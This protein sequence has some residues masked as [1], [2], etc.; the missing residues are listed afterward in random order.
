MTTRNPVRVYDFTLK[1][2]DIDEDDIK[3]ILKK[4]CKKWTFQLEEGIKDGYMHY[5]GRIHL[6]EK[7]RF[8]QMKTYQPFKNQCSWSVTSSGNINNDDYVEKSDTRVKG[9]WS[10]DDPEPMYVP[11]QVRDIKLREWQ[12][13]IYSQWNDFDRRSINVL[14]DY[15]GNIGKS[16]LATIMRCQGKAVVIPPMQD[17]KD[18]MRM[19]CDTPTSGMYIVDLPRALPNQS[20]LAGMYSAIEQIKSGWAWDDRYKFRQKVFDSPIIWVF[21]NSYPNTTL[22]SKDR[23]KIWKVQDDNLVRADISDD[24]W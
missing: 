3:K 15:E 16:V 4:K 20:K 6:R 1:A 13:S 5:Q 14:I 10:S 19:V 2:K 11:A 12:L 9:P 17:P 21:T 7:I 23:W 22:L 18:I 24:E 8:N